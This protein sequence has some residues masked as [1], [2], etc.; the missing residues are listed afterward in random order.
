M[1][2]SAGETTATVT[3][4]ITDENIAESTEDFSAVLTIPIDASSLGVNKGAT[5]TASID[6]EDNDDV[7]L[8]FNPTQYTVNEGDGTVTL[9]LTSDRV[10]AC[11]Y[12]VEIITQ[13]G[14]ASGQCPRLKQY[15]CCPL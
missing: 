9:T 5:D 4:P 6:I 8:N 3:I 13:D 7:E 11:S 15:M 1:T 2:F 14:S 10:A 12:T